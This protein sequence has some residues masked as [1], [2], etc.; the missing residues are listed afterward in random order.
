M[1]CAKDNGTQ[2]CDIKKICNIFQQRY[3]IVRV[4]TSINDKC[5]I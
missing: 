5:Q 4:A 1:E 3:H 2:N